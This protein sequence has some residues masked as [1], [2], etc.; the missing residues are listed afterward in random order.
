MVTASDGVK[1]LGHFVCSHILRRD[2]PAR[3]YDSQALDQEYFGEKRSCQNRN[4]VKLAVRAQLEGKLRTGKELE[5]LYLFRVIFIGSPRSGDAAKN[6]L[7]VPFRIV[8][9]FRFLSAVTMSRR[10]SFVIA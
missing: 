4:T 7:S 3:R 9:L 2:C 5:D 6:S 1:N 10:P 8:F